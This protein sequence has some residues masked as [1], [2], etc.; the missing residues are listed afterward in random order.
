MRRLLMVAVALVVPFAG[1][2]VETAGPAMAASPGV[3]CTRYVF[4]QLT[5]KHPIEFRGCNDVASTGGSGTTPE[6]TFAQD[7]SKGTITWAGTGTTKIADAHF[8]Y[9]T[10]D[11]CPHNGF[12]AYATFKVTGGTG[13]AAQSIPKGWVLRVET[14]W[15]QHNGNVKLVAG[16]VLTIGS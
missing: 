6:S 2:V 10:P 11:V 15:N 4:N 1:L 9:P 7:G 13:A 12:E 5:D 16:T 3:T 14:C 8:T